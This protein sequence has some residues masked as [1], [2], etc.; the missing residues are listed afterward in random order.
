MAPVLRQRGSRELRQLLG[1]GRVE[2]SI[3]EGFLEEDKAEY[4][5]EGVP[6]YGRNSVS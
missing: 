3:K 2:V 5:E 4:K 6:G 1:K